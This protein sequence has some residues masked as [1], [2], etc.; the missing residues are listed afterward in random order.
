MW[1]R[2]G[3][4]GNIVNLLGHWDISG[5]VAMRQGGGPKPHVRAPVASETPP[6]RAPPSVTN[7]TR[8]VPRVLLC[9]YFLSRL[10]S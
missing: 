6:G 2:A 10:T 7:S 5:E 3:D 4:R 8:V 9:G 1:E